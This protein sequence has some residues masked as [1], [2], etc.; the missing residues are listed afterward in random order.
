MTL[1]FVAKRENGETIHLLY[2]QDKK[3]LLIL[4]E[5]ERFFCP[6]CGKE[7]QLKLG[8]QKVWHFAHKNI[9]QCIG[10]AEPESNYHMRGK[11]QLYRWIISQKIRAEIEKYIPEIRQRPDILIERNGKS[12]A[13]E[14]Q[15][16]SI[17]T[18]QLQKRT[19]AYQKAGIQIIWILGGNQ[20]KRN[21]PYWTSVSSFHAFCIQSY[22]QPY[23]LFFCPD[24]KIFQKCIFLTPFS[25]NIHFAHIIP[26]SIR[27]STFENIF[28][29]I[30]FRKGALERVW[31]NK[32]NLF[33]MH[34][35]PIWNDHQ[36]ALLRM[37]YQLKISPSIFPSEIGVPLPSAFSFQTSPFIWQAFLYLDFM[38]NFKRGDYFSLHA[39]FSYVSNKR[40]WKR[41][42]LPYFPQHIWKLAII[43]YMDFLC[44]TGMIEKVGRYK[45]RKV[46][47]ITL[48]KTEKEI[49]KY[50]AICLAHAISLFEAK[51]NM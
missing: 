35:L 27:T 7:V 38:E 34:A 26:F 33:R 32:K 20:L 6:A 29:Q 18:N 51:Y 10:S 44:S 47:G 4:R 22:P 11:E 25:T 45:Y 50:D 12:L 14:Y 43:E 3:T 1:L 41:R 5:R 28:Q 40:N 17:S 15:C 36:K 30:P 31:K 37:F 46:K 9:E 39:V 19:Y 42:I 23:L 2:H 48:L 13:L 8:N 16:T 21:A 49:K 24:K